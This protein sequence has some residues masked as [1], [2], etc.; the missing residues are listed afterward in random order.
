MATISDILSVKPSSD[1]ILELSA[2]IWLRRT[3]NTITITRYFKLYN[4]SRSWAIEVDC[5]VDD[6]SKVNK[7]IKECKEKIR[8]KREFVIPMHGMTYY[9]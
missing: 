2:T 1:E 8:E 4:N 9:V 3:K 6:W 5:R 7:H